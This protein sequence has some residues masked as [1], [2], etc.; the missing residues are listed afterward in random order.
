MVDNYFFENNK[1]YLD[2][3]DKLFYNFFESIDIETK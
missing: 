2:F 1:F 3:I